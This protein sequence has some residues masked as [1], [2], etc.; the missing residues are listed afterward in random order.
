VVTIQKDKY[1]NVSPYPIVV[2]L[3]KNEKVSLLKN[4]LKKL[5][6][7]NMDI[8][9]ATRAEEISWQQA[10]CPWN[11]VDVTTTHKCAVKNISI[12]PYFCGVEYLDTILCCYPNPNPLAK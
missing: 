12:C 10:P 7:A 11:Q 8:D 9:L 1:N 6:G 4:A 5:T 3:I 2:K